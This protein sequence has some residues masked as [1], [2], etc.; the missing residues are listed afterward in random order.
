MANISLRMDVDTAKCVSVGLPRIAALCA[1]KKV[2]LSVFLLPGRAIR[3]KDIFFRS[4]QGRE[5]S[6]QKTALSPA[7]KLGLHWVF[8]TLFANERLHRLITRSGLWQQYP[9]HFVGLHGTYNHSS[10]C[11][12]VSFEPEKIDAGLIWGIKKLESVLSS[13]LGFAS[14]CSNTPPLFEEALVRLGFKYLADGIAPGLH[15][16]ESAPGGLEL[17]STGICGPNGEGFLESCHA[18]R[19]SEIEVMNKFDELLAN[20][21]EGVIYGHPFFDGDIGLQLLEKFIDEVKKRGHSW[22]PMIP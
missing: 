10:W 7:E 11:A 13:N 12:G 15:N 20:S 18:Q 22:V 4:A 6:K 9:P 19:L 2:P 16:R 1:N 14:P 5:S 21:E 17:I 3:R 8:R